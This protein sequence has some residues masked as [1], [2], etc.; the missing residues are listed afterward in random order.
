MSKDIAHPVPSP[1]YR[2]AHPALRQIGCPICKSPHTQLELHKTVVMKGPVQHEELGPVVG[3]VFSVIGKCD[4]GHHFILRVANHRETVLVW[5]DVV[6]DKQFDLPTPNK[7]PVFDQPMVKGDPMGI[8]L[9]K[10]ESSGMENYPTYQAM[11]KHQPPPV[12]LGK[13]GDKRCHAGQPVLEMLRMLEE[14]GYATAVCLQ[15]PDVACPVNQNLSR[16]ANIRAYNIQAC[17]G[18]HSG[19][20]KKP[21]EKFLPKAQKALGK[22]RAKFKALAYPKTHKLSNGERATL[23]L[24]LRRMVGLA[25]GRRAAK[26][27]QIHFAAHA[28]ATL[29]DMLKDCKLNTPAKKAVADLLI[30]S[31]I[32]LT[33][34]YLLGNVDAPPKPTLKAPL[35]P[36]PTLKSVAQVQPPDENSKVLG[37]PDKLTLKQAKTA[38]CQ[39]HYC[40]PCSV[41]TC[42]L[43]PKNQ[44]K[45]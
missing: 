12:P 13:D 5:T 15:C 25:A 33:P 34:D 30:P 8:E 31:G 21:H 27:P 38:A 41:L 23:I 18:A 42:A 14:E 16:H 37:C 45:V 10:V 32:N 11:Q 7:Y 4:K 19:P 20:P 9:D 1:L 17:V 39:K 2:L 6:V 36:K 3:N 28:V 29:A 40:A 24:E 44:P 43:H 35:P 26:F 22:L